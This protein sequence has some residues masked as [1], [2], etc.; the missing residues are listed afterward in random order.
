MA[1]FVKANADEMCE[2]F[3]FDKFMEAIE[4]SEKRRPTRQD[5]EYVSMGRARDRRTRDHYASRIRFTR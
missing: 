3:E 2:E 1:P 4:E 5:E